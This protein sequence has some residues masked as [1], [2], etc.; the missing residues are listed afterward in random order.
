MTT[1][2]NADDPQ[3][4]ALKPVA[5]DVWI[6][7]G[8][9]LRPLGLPMPIRMTVFRLESGDLWLHSPIRFGAGLVGDLEKLGRI[10]HLVAPNIAH[11]SFVAEW[12]QHCPAALVWA[13]PNLRR[14]WQVRKAG[15]RIDRDLGEQPPHDWAADVD[16]T[17][18][19]GG[20]G[21]REGAFFHR[22]TRT[23]VLT[24][25]IVNL[26]AQKLPSRT[27]AFAR[28]TGTLAPDGKA[29]VY[30]RLL[31]R[32]RRKEAAAAV[33]RMIGWA[34]ERVIFA[35]GRWFERDGTERLKRSLA[36]LLE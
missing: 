8:E 16:Q 9:P 32:M 24:D 10:R 13:A 29:P 19:P 6:V 21:F 15:L 34:P 2:A 35:H 28:A 36:W 14:R 30:L 11:W 3:L 23:L 26:E 22:T 18:V 27:R 17:I 5:E 12:Q 25:L 33:S 7:D 31:V 1:S 4:N 20:F